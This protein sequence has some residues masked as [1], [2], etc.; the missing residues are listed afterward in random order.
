M[1]HPTKI[2]HYIVVAIQI[3]IAIE[4]VG[5][6]AE[7]F[8]TDDWSRLGS[9]LFIAGVLFLLWGRIKL[10]VA[11][12]RTQVKEQMEGGGEHLKLWDALAFSLLWSDE[13]YK[14]IPRDRNRLILISYT[15]IAIGVLV[16][17]LTSGLM[18]F[19]ASSALV[20][21]A[22]NLVVWVVSTER[23]EKESLQTELQLASQVQVSLMPKN[24]PVVPGF[25]ISGRSVPAQEVGGD[26]FTYRVVRDDFDVA[27]F[28]VSGKG[29][30]A[31][32]SAVFI[33]GSL[34]SELE[35]GRSPAEVLT[36]LNRAFYTHSSRGNFV[37]FLL[38]SV[39]AQT[40][41]LVFANAGQV[42]PLH[43]SSAGAK[44]LDGNGVNFPLGM[45]EHALYNNR[46]VRLGR[47]EMLLLLTD[48]VTEAM[49]GGRELF[50]AERL[51]ALVCRPDLPKLP[52]SRV[53]DEVLDN[54]RRHMGNAPQ[55]DDMT[56]VVIRV[57]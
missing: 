21:A 9:D 2:K 39:N 18:A 12:K 17:Y 19:I 1:M 14:G 28:D 36:N 37:S 33:N 41:S 38:A 22:V 46:E 48:G 55:H 32:M 25:D 47:G 45:V 16:A 10:K 49:N 53:I 42:K 54:I 7:G 8:T 43:L 52:A 31:A 5:A 56:L 34:A 27:V 11:Q 35:S 51:E 50:S 3:L 4:L 57:L 23:G 30:H 13:I 26:H 6:A 29:M 15:L 44:W 20:L 40:R 24:D